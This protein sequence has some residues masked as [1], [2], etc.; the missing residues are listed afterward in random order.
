MVERGQHFT[1]ANWFAAIPKEVV[2]GSAALLLWRGAAGLL[3]GPAAAREDL[4]RACALFKEAGDV[5]GQW[6]AWCAAIETYMVEFGWL[7]LL[8]TRWVSEFRELRQA[9]PQFPSRELE[10]RALGNYLWTYP[11]V[12]LDEG[13]YRECAE[14]PWVLA[15]ETADAGGRRR[16]ASPPVAWFCCRGDLARVR[17]LLET[18]RPESKQTCPPQAWIMGQIAEL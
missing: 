17:I 14:R 12:G 18:L 16:W 8:F 5:A 2:D 7:G 9:H 10:A 15:R 11:P 13:E 6:S 1:I 3:N 4:S